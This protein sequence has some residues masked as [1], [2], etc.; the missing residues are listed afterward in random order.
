MKTVCHW[1]EE[2][3]LCAGKQAG[4]EAAGFVWAQCCSHCLHCHFFSIS[5]IHASVSPAHGFGP[6]AVSIRIVGCGA[7]QVLHGISCRLTADWRAASPDTHC[8]IGLFV[9][10]DLLWPPE[11][12]WMAVPCL[13]PGADTVQVQSLGLHRST[14]MM[15]M[16]GAERVPSAP[17]SNLCQSN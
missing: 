11:Q 4:G 15:L 7:A 16:C 2:I 9:C 8:S 14:D 13:L 6:S 17:P 5:T 1:P 10:R 12:R 3:G